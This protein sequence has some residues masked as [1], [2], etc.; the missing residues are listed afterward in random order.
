[1]ANLRRLLAYENPNRVEL[2]KIIANE[3]F[4]EVPDMPDAYSNSQWGF[5][6]D[7]GKSG[8]PVVSN[9]RKVYRFMKENLPKAPLVDLG[10]GAIFGYPGN[11]TMLRAAEQLGL[12]AYIGVDRHN[13][14][15]GEPNLYTS[16]D[17]LSKRLER[18][19]NRDELPEFTNLD[20]EVVRADMLDFV[21]R[22]I[23][24]VYNFSI[25]GIDH[26]I[27]YDEGSKYSKTLA[28]ELARASKKGSIVLGCNSEAFYHLARTGFKLLDVPADS[29]M[30]NNIHGWIFKKDS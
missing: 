13:V 11:L 7:H 18:Y 22:M 9:P 21:S 5:I 12:P 26:N 24:G 28:T 17:D 8:S 3:R 2:D 23:A 20:V 19:R 25:N 30:K 4:A 15:T 1:M 10:C 29:K 6:E 27:L 16:I 14:G